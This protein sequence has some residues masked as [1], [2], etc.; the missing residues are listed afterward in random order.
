M[1]LFDK[2][3]STENRGSTL[4]LMK[5][6]YKQFSYTRKKRLLFVLLYID[7]FLSK[8]TDDKLCQS[9]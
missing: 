1:C 5:G 4:P 6:I 9:C 2:K 8:R 3:T 7:D